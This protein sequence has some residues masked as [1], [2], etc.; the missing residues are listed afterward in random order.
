MTANPSDIPEPPRGQRILIIEDDEQLGE[1]VAAFLSDWGNLPRRLTLP[2][3]AA[4]SEALAQSELAEPDVEAVAIVSRDDIVALRYALLAEHLRPGVRLVVT[5]F[6]RTTAGE[7]AHRVPNCTVLAM[8]DAI[9]PTLLA[10]SGR[11]V[12]PPAASRRAGAHCCTGRPGNWI[13]STSAQAFPRLAVPAVANPRHLS[14]STCRRLPGHPRQAHG[15]LENATI[16]PFENW[17][18]AARQDE[19]ARGAVTATGR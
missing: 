9:V 2:D 1:P 19:L 16:F 18:A 12:T 13:P 10:A 3:D 4:L 7:V 17:S 14:A 6:D 11:P 8:P 15:V 5:I